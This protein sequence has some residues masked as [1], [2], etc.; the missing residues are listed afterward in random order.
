MA[1]NLNVQV[2]EQFRRNAR[3]RLD[4]WKACLQGVI[5]VKKLSQRPSSP[6]IPRSIVAVADSM[7]ADKNGGFRR[8]RVT[9]AIL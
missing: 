1:P 6:L 8:A 7:S 4:S 3:I 5:P 2:S 9:F